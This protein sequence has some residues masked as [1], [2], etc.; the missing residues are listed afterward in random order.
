MIRIGGVGRRRGDNPTS[1]G[2]GN[3]A[4]GA[5]AVLGE[6]VWAHPSRRPRFLRLLTLGLSNQQIADECF[7]SI[8]S[9]EVLHPL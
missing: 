7:L 5:Y 8:N 4:S 2:H 1:T 3:D 6:D 9:V